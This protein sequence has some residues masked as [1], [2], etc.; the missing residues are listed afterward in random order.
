MAR[1]F[2]R[3][4]MSRRNLVSPTERPISALLLRSHPKGR[5]RAATVDGEWHRGEA[6]TLAV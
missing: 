6:L 5:Q 2:E 1:T 4:I 3:F